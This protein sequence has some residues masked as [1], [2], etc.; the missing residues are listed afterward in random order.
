MQSRST[1]AKTANSALYNTSNK[2]YGGS[3]QRFDVGWEV[4]GTR[5]QKLDIRKASVPTYSEIVN[6]MND[7]KKAERLIKSKVLK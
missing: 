7:F 4:D 2:E 6:S 3:I 5:G 1:F